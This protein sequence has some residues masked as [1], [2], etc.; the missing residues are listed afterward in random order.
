MTLPPFEL[1]DDGSPDEEWLE[2]FRA[3][4]LDPKEAAQFLVYQ[5]PVIANTMF[6][7][8]EVSESE[9][10]Y[11]TIKH[12]TAGWSGAEDLIDAMLDKTWIAMWQSCWLRG[13]Y[14]EFL[15]PRGLVK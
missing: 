13:G 4:E 11:C 1:G 15:V 2:A 9:K 5:F 14:Y 8:A 7:W 12:A 10:G 6:S 3:C